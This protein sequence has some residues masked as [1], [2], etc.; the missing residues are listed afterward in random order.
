MKRSQN[1]LGIGIYTIP[2]AARLTDVSTPRIRRWLL[3]YQFR[4]KKEVH[5][6]PPVWKPDLPELEGALALT[7]RD[8]LEVRFVE[9]FLQKGVSWRVLREAAVY[10]GHVVRSGHPF[11]TFKFK[12]DGKRI[13]ADFV[14]ERRRVL[15]ELSA[16]Q[17]SMPPIVDRYLYEGIEFEGDN[18]ARWFPMGRNHAVVIDPSVGFGQPTANPE[19]VPTAILA[20]AFRVERSI[21]RVARWY[22]VPEPTVESAVEYERK[23]AA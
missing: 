5:E 15:L 23:L 22:Q 1:L 13:F 4:T 12:T 19:G 2:E 16:R 11:S 3:G 18:P 21:Q 17:Y 6:S 7:F 9:Y 8:L 10:A 14:E 20:N